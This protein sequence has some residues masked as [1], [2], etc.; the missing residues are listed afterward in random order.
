MPDAF[1]SR[2][3]QELRVLCDRFPVRFRATG[4]RLCG[5]RLTWIADRREEL[6]RGI[7]RAVLDLTWV[8]KWSPGK[9]SSSRTPVR[10]PARAA[11]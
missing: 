3:P 9:P 4:V 11:R 10:K 1:D 2:P 8:G 5:Y 6:D 7:E